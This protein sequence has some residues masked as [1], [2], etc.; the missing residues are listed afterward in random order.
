MEK[1]PCQERWECTADTRLP[2]SRAVGSIARLQVDS[3][4]PP[5]PLY[6]HVDVGVILQICLQWI[7]LNNQSKTHN[8]TNGIEHYK[9]KKQ[10]K[11]CVMFTCHRWVWIANSGWRDWESAIKRAAASELSQ[12]I[13]LML[14]QSS[15]HS[16]PHP[17]NQESL[18]GAVVTQLESV[19]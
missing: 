3:F 16:H 11:Q 8:D 17:P 13:F 5:P 12:D 2:W 10:I 4:S 1:Y 19:I 15:S 18:S 14:T 9:N 7:N 6:P